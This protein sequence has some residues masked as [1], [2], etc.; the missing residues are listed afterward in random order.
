MKTTTSLS[1][2]GPTSAKFRAIPAEN[3][4]RGFCI[5]DINEYPQEINILLVASP[6][7]N[8]HFL[9]DLREAV[10]KAF[11]YELEK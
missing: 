3:G 2:Q 5:I 10:E 8:L 9:Y 4:G 7:E 6:A 1:M 11:K